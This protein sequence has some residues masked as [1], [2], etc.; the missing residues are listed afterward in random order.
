M[1][2]LAFNLLKEVLNNKKAP[3]KGFIVDIVQYKKNTIALRIYRDNIETFSEGQKLDL[4]EWISDRLKFA[5]TISPS[6]YIFGLEV[7]DTWK[8]TT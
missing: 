1:A 3:H 5:K 4:Y 2:D 6:D 8:T 7:E